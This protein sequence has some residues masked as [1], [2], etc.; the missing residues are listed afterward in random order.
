MVVRPIM[1]SMLMTTPD[2]KL[3][4]PKVRSIAVYAEPSL[5]TC[6]PSLVLASLFFLF[7]VVGSP[8]SILVSSLVIGVR[9]ALSEVPTWTSGVSLLPYTYI[10]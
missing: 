2:T 10:W 5:P 6:L 9:P 3:P 8:N 7:T 4:P 1:S